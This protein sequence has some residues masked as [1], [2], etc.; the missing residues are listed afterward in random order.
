[1]LSAQ[2][3]TSV[4]VTLDSTTMLAVTTVT[5]QTL[6]AMDKRGKEELQIAIAVHVVPQLEA[7]WT[8]TTSIA[9]IARC[10]QL[11]ENNVITRSLQ[12]LGQVFVG[13]GWIVLLGVAEKAP[14]NMLGVVDKL[15]S[16]VAMEHVNSPMKIQ[17]AALLIV[18]T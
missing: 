6:A 13:D 12:Q 3:T 9:G 14:L 18:V 1:M 16:S 8:S 7:E 2:R 11:V 4:Q 10:N 5:I 15:W 17:T